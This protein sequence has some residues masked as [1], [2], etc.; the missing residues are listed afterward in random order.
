[1]AGGSVRVCVLTCTCA[2]WQSTNIANA[3]APQ[4]R[5]VV[6]AEPTESASGAEDL[7]E[8]AEK[9]Q[10]TEVSMQQFMGCMLLQQW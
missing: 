10:K 3:P 5:E 6:T 1:M 2:C 8:L 7:S 9:L 4:G